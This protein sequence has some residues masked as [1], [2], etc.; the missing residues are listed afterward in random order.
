MA[1]LSV[2][3]IRTQ[4]VVG[5]VLWATWAAV[6]QPEWT[7]VL[8][9]LSPLVLVPL[10]LRL[11]SADTIGPGVLDSLSRLTL[12]LALTAAASF[13]PGPGWVAA[14]VSVPWFVFTALLALAG[15][16]RLLSRRSILE[17]GIGV[18]FGLMFVVV[19]GA[20]LTIS[21]A[22]ANPL[23]FS[24]AIVQ[25]TAV[26]FHYAGFALPIVAGF[27]ADRLRRSAI[28]PIA[29]IVGVP[30]TAAG[31]TIGGW[32]E[33]IAATLMAMAGIA[34]AALLI[35][36]GTT[37]RGLARWLTVT[38]GIALTAGMTLAI[39]W[40]WALRFGWTFLGLETMAATHGSLN[41]LGFGLLGLVGL[42][43]LMEQAPTTPTTVVSLHLGRPGPDLLERW[44]NAAA[45]EATTN[46]VGLLDRP[47]PAGFQRTTWHRPIDHCDFGTAVEAIEQWRGHEAAGIRR[48]PTAP[49]IVEGSTLALAIPVGP[50]A[51]SATSRI[52]RVI[53]EPDRFGFVYSTLPHHPV[54]GEESFIVR[55][56]DDGALDVTVTAVW[57][58]STLA[59]HVCPPI[60]RWLQNRAINQYLDGI[61]GQQ[62]ATVAPL[63]QGV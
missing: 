57:R 51:V 61:A 53:D 28:V 36:C 4:A 58:A 26:H 63:T 38:A 31:I 6:V 30:L 37:A 25:L 8:L 7:A 24:D 19:G 59:N 21:R 44:A 33:W 23:G 5:L 43:L 42:N 17:P 49:A 1:S 50:I 29:V 56:H 48:W 22:G 39:G 45:D 13:I 60:T 12:P 41:A 9:L 34:T 62:A 55:R 52:V 11:A 47:V 14:L 18:D 15:L 16:A 40:A 10:G 2:T 35:R 20:W 27:T 46:Q 32:L 3:T 54:D